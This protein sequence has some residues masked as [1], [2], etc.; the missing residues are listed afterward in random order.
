MPVYKHSETGIE[1]VMLPEQAAVYGDVFVQVADES[2]EEEVSRLNREAILNKVAVE[3]ENGN[4]ITVAE[5][6]GETLRAGSTSVG[7]VG[8]PAPDDEHSYAHP[9][10]KKGGDQ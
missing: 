9:V 7:S 4:E 6:L 3:D 8:D 1:A 10:N 2:P 5:A